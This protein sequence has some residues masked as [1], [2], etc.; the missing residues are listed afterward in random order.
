MTWKICLTSIVT[1]ALLACGGAKDAG[2]SSGGVLTITADKT[3]VVANGVNQVLVHVTGSQKGPVVIR[4]DRGGFLEASGAASASNPTTP[5]D[6]TLVTCDSRVLPNTACVGL[7]RVSASDG[8]LATGVLQV[9]FV[10]MEICNNGI[11][12]DGNG[13]IDCADTVACPAGTTCS[14]GGKTCGGGTCSVCSGKGGAPEVAETSCGDGFDND[15]DGLIDC[16]DPD[17]SGKVCNSATSTAGGLTTGVCGATTKLCTCT[18]TPET[19]AKC[20]DGLDN[21]CDGLIDGQDPDCAGQPCDAKGNLWSPSSPGLPSTCSVCSGNGGAVQSPETNCADGKDNDCTGAADCADSNCYTSTYPCKNVTYPAAAGWTC[22]AVDRMC[23]VCGGNGGTPQPGRETSCG[24]GFDNDC[25]GL[26][27]CADPDCRNTACNAFGMK[28]TNNALSTN[29]CTVCTA[30]PAQV[31]ETSCGDG[32]DND[33]DGF[34]DC[35]DPNCQ[36]AGA[37]PGKACLANGFLCTAAGACACSGNGG[38]AQATETSCADGKDNDCDGSIDC[39]DSDCLGQACVRPTGGSV[40]TVCSAAGA[41]VCSGNGGTPQATETSCSDGFDNDCDGLIDCQDPDCGGKACVFAVPGTARTTAGVCNATSKTCTCTPVPETGA[42]CGD[43]IDNDCDGLV[44]CADPGCQPVGNGLGGSCD[45]KGNTCAPA[46][47]GVSTCSRCAPGGDPTKF[48]PVETSCGDGLDNDCSGLADCQDPNCLAQG[49]ACRI[50]AKD[51]GMVCTTL[52]SGGGVCQCPDLSGPETKCKDGIDNDCNGYTDCKDLNCNGRDCGDYGK[53]CVTTANGAGSCTCPGGTTEICNDQKDN[54]CDNLIDCADPTCQPIGTAT[55]GQTCRTDTLVSNAACTAGGQCVCTG[56]Q[57]TESTCNDNVDNDCDGFKDCLDL[58]CN[59]KTCLS[60]GKVGMVCS[61]TANGTG[62]CVCPGGGTEIC[63]DGID[64]DCNGLVDCADPACQ[65][66][67]TST[68]G[69]ACNPANANF[70]CRYVGTAW[71]CK[72]TSSYLLTVVASPSRIPANG[73]ATATVTVKLLD[74][75]GGSPVPKA[76]ATVALATDLGGLAPTSLV[77]N[78]SGLATST[79][80]AS[81]IAGTATLTATY[82]PPAGLPTSG[83]GAVTLPALSQITLAS[84]DFAVMG[85]RDSGYQ[86]LNTLTFLLT[87]SSGQPYPAGLRVDFEHAPAGASYIEVT[88]QPFS[89]TATLCTTHGVTDAG[90]LVSVLLHSGSVAATVAVTAK[91]SAG[92]TGLKTFTAGNIAIVGAKASGDQMTI[93]CSPQNVPALISTDCT[94]S[95]YFGSDAN[96]KCQVVLADRFGLKLGVPTLVQFK[97]E[98]GNVTPSA[99][100][101]AYSP[102]GTNASLGITSGT[103]SVGGAKLPMDVL[104]QGLPGLPNFEYSDVHDLDGCGAS[105]GKT[106]THNPRDGLVTVIAYAQ[107]EEGFFD[108][109]NGCPADGKYNPPL[110]AGCPLGEKFVDLGEPFVDIDDDGERDSIANGDLFD[111]PY[112]DVNNNG[113]WDGPNGA[114]DANTTIWAET[115]ILYTGYVEALPAGPVGAPTQAASRVYDPLSIPSPFTPAFTPEAAFTDVYA[116]RTTPAPGAPAT[117]QRFGVFMTDLNFNIPNYKTT[118]GASK[119]PSNVS[120]TATLNSAPTTADGLGMLF[121][122]L[123]CDGT[124][125]GNP[126]SCSTSCDWNVCLRRADIAGFQ[127]GPMGSLTVT[128]GSKFESGCAYV[129]ATLRTTNTISSISTERSIDIGVCGD[130]PLAP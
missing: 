103:Y 122:Q 39:A 121:R 125:G 126:A 47:A 6:V 96:I 9:R 19:G 118:Y 109:S 116:S 114:W 8:N 25:D 68:D 52:P 117:S 97:A 12:D 120:F 93:T 102:G 76:G 115:R 17:C 100:T 95:T 14:A 4:T 5:F 123:Y 20:A 66:A 101:P 77:T 35:A 41:C 110:S 94:N 108:G 21:D 72:D 130:I 78:G 24:D 85:A 104:P 49:L 84:Q 3:Q 57:A 18:P 33:C 15:C 90:G 87:D 26:V 63:T 88:G 98:A 106:I 61:T 38:V 69:L 10:G 74:T 124:L 48:Q 127:Y 2:S 129:T 83:I 27:D 46:V 113:I 99:T 1:A 55:W 107:G 119:S 23:T 60:P 42:L 30:V 29:T 40:G 59:G 43:G 65:G 81:A 105:L 80:T 92:G 11:D 51:T 22:S 62:S 36:P 13:L 37:V 58:D 82:T 86:E 31:T 67:T 54:N 28:C 44:D 7:A 73:A 50:G 53:V 64:N 71:T 89:C 16:D 34:T 45:T 32:I 56:G 128:G 75:S 70:K 111:E 112:I 79:F 91:A